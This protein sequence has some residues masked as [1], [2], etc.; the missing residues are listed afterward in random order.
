RYPRTPDRTQSHP[1]LVV[2]QARVGNDEGPGL[3]DRAVH[4]EWTGIPL[5]RMQS[6]PIASHVLN[7]LNM[8]L[9]EANAASRRPSARPCPS[10]HPSIQAVGR[11]CPAVT[12][13]IRR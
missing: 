5:H 4:F 8:L 12:N 10:W 11:A 6:D 3:V 1:R 9:P 7:A 13:M 2:R